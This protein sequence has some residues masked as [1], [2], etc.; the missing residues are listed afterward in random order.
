MSNSIINNNDLIF[1]CGN[2]LLLIITAN[3]EGNTHIYQAKN[4]YIR[5]SYRSLPTGHDQFLRPHHHVS[6]LRSGCHGSIRGQIPLVE[7]LPDHH[8]TDPVHHCNDCLRCGTVLP[9]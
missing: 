7:A 9:M 6:V 3:N 2:G 1:T 4:V 8:P 5:F